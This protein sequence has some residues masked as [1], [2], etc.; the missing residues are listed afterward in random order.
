MP[1]YHV[2]REGECIS[3]IALAYG[4]FRGTLENHPE[5]A[6]LCRLR[7]NLNTL[8]PGDVVFI[9]EKR[10]GTRQCETGRRHR[11]LRR[12]VPEQLRVRFLDRTGRPRARFAY[13]LEVDG[14]RR[15]GRLNQEGWLEE[16]VWPGARMATIELRGGDRPEVYRFALRRLPPIDEIAGI[17]ARLRNL[18]FY[19]GEINQCL[20]DATFAAIQ[21]FQAAHGMSPSGVVD[22]ATLTALAHAYEGRG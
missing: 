5:N 2:V 6:E 4:F 7:Q 20:D 13:A 22:A 18:G 14:V 12:G 1:K 21:R 19:D 16:R 10:V 15:E 8:M 3:S 11:F 9:P 17:Q